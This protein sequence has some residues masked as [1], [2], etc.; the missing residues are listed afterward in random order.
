MDYIIGKS[1]SW[2]GL[3]NYRSK[4][5]VDFKEQTNKNNTST[6]IK[7]SL[8][9]L[10]FLCQ[11]LKVLLSPAVLAVCH[12]GVSLWEGNLMGWFAS[13]RSSSSSSPAQPLYLPCAI[14]L[15]TNSDFLLSAWKPIHHVS[16]FNESRSTLCQ[17]VVT[18][19]VPIW[20]SWSGKKKNTCTYHMHIQTNAV[21]EVFFYST[22]FSVVVEN[23]W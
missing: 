17:N 12:Q 5:V 18:P 21:C 13:K 1:R 14:H 11:Q 19:S 2:T 10:V 8:F 16:H 4:A 6:C 22:E 9:S 7:A 15:V 23:V 20:E 3:Q